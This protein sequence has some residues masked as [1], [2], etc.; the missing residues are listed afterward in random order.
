MTA[1]QPIIWQ[2]SSVISNMCELSSV[3]SKIDQNPFGKTLCGRYL[4][5][6]GNRTPY[7]RTAVGVVI[8]RHTPVWVSRAPWA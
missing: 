1:C 8:V 5:P 3:I 4:E 6:L 2:F 7:E